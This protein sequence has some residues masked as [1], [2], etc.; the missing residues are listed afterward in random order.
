MLCLILSFGLQARSFESSLHFRFQQLDTSKGWSC[1]V[2][3]H[4]NTHSWIWTAL[5]REHPVPGH[6]RIM[7]NHFH[8]FAIQQI[9]LQYWKHYSGLEP[10][11]LYLAQREFYKQT[12]SKCFQGSLLLF[13]HELSRSNREFTSCNPRAELIKIIN[14]ISRE[15]VLWL[16]ELLT[17]LALIM[18]DC[19]FYAS[20]NRASPVLLIQRANW[21]NGQNTSSLNKIKD[22]NIISKGS[23]H[24]AVKTN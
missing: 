10:T 7:T 17:S 9:P 20:W 19:Y 1:S 15:I 12:K 3:Q 5:S 11:W 4:P 24:P 8:S 23:I 18:L 16:P 14:R 2:L 6:V 22:W 21:I 13:G